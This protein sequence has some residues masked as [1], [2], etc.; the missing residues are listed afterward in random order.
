MGGI[1]NNLV[2][3]KCADYPARMNDEEIRKLAK[4]RLKAQLDFRSI[5]WVWFGV[6]AL[7]IVIWFLT[8]PGGYFWPAW[9][10]LGIGVAVV[11]QAFNAYGPGSRFV[12]EDDIT[13]EVE[14]LKRQPRNSTKS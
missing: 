3:S 10:M 11:A 12:T 5:V 8:S 2:V 13:A 7:L 1:R 9:A 4:N 6:S 14:R